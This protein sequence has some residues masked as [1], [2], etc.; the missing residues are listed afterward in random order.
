MTAEINY[1]GLEK[2]NAIVVYLRAAPVYSI[3]D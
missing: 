1:T 2:E 3:E